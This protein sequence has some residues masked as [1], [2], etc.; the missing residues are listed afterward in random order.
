M[1]KHLRIARLF[2]AAIVLFISAMQLPA[3]Q[4]EDEVD[5]VSL[6][7]ISPQVVRVSWT[8]VPLGNCGGS[9]TYSVFRDTRDDFY[10]SD[11]NKVASGIV[12]THY[13]SHEP[14]SGKN[15]YYRVVPV[16]LQS[17]CNDTGAAPVSVPLSLKSGRIRVYPLDFGEKYKV[18]IGD[19]IK[20]CDAMSVSELNCPNLSN[21]HAVIASQLGREFLIGC[22]SSDYEDNN[23]TCVNLGLGFY[24]IS[25]HSRTAT[26]LDSGFSRIN[27]K[28]GKVIGT[29]TPEFSIL[30]A[31]Q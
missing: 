30:S 18:T 15:W 12:G 3:Q 10:P 23:W 14:K 29:I 31:L 17:N 20:V 26:I 28:T 5:S 7:V 1:A 8:A 6:T 21:F 22:L 11:V 19:E 25:V 9:I 16:R 24:G 2:T 27:T 13:F 4:P